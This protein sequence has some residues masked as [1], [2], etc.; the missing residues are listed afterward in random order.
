MPALS[1]LEFLLVSADY[2]ILTAVSGSVKKFGAKL[3]LVPT[4]DEA[5]EYLSR[6]R[7]DAIFVDMQTYGAVGLIEAVRKGSSNARAAIFACVADSKESTGTLNAGANF[8]LHKPLTAD[9]VALHLTIAKEIMLRERRRYFRHPVT[10]PVSLR[11]ESAEQQAKIANLSEGGMAVRSGRPL[12]HGGIVEFAFELAF[13]EEIRGRGLVAW[14]SS[15]GMAGILI[16]TLQGLGRGYL[17]MW[18]RSR[19]HFASSAG[20]AAEGS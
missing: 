4:A 14:T 11:E 15:E 13:G 2:A 5:R 12:K 1:E 16:Q 9:S 18:L 6:R 19:E 10:L 8:L 3:A 20:T 17:E 7:I